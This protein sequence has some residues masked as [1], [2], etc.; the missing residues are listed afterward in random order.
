MNY[1]DLEVLRMLSDNTEDYI[2]ALCLKLSDFSNKNGHEM[3]VFRIDGFLSAPCMLSYCKKCTYE[4]AID[5]F[6]KDKV[7]V[8]LSDVDKKCHK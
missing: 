1:K 3:S 6:P 5:L 7:Y 4:I 8:D 2:N